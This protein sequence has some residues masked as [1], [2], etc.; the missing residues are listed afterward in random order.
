MKFEWGKPKAQQNWSKH[1]VTFEEA[2]T[3]FEDPLCVDL[4]DPDHSLDEESYLCIGMS[5][6]RRLLIASYT[7]RE[8]STRLISAREV[9]REERE[10][11]EEG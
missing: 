9:T 4:Y 7:E 10:A 3:I 2:K 5:S 6:Q 8:D 11:Y 1:K